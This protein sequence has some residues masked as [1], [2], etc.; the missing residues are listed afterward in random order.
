MSRSLKEKAKLLMKEKL[1]ILILIAFLPSA[2]LGA[3]SLTAVGTILALPISV[4]LSY[5]FIQVA[6]GGPGELKDLFR[7]LEGNYYLNHLW[8]LIK[9]GIFIVLWSLLLVIPAIVKFYSYSQT[10]FILADDPNEKDAI[11]KSRMMMNGHKLELF[12]L[13]F[14]FIGWFILSG[15]TFGLVW[16]FYVGP[17]YNQTMALYY[18]ALKER[19]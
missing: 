9:M 18:L 19:Q 11:T 17:Y 7:S 6:N 15:L 2:L 8:T 13:Q 16:I 5:A 10:P 14:S 12:W 4:G 1:G 3:L